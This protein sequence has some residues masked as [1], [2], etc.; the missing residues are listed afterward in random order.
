MREIHNAYGCCKRGD[1]FDYYERFR[2]ST[3]ERLRLSGINDR[4]HLQKLDPK[5]LQRLETAVS[6]SEY[7]QGKKLKVIPK[8]KHN[9]DP[10][11][12]KS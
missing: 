8:V 10:A 7:S 6:K 3:T 11:L 9:D 12:R 2:K 5:T 4:I 1:R